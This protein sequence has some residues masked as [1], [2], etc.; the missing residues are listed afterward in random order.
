[1][2]AGTKSQGLLQLCCCH[3]LR[4][5]GCL[6]THPLAG[7]TSPGLSL[8]ETLPVNPGCR[9]TH[10]SGWALL[11]VAAELNEIS[12]LPTRLPTKG[13]GFE[14]SVFSDRHKYSK[15]KGTLTLSTYPG[16]ETMKQTENEMSLLIKIAEVILCTYTC[17]S[18]QITTQDR[19]KVMNLH[20]TH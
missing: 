7:K 4:D 14:R 6:R 13:N 3:P 16:Q 9:G 17:F 2:E 18:F 12:P 10:H 11:T 5:A 1:M 20:Q 15:T 19:D 8:A